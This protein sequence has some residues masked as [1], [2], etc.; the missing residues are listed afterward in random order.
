M[1][2]L[3]GGKYCKD[4]KVFC[5][6]VE[7]E[8]MKLIYN[9]VDSRAFDGQKIRIMP[10][11][12]AG[13]GIV[14]GF[15][16]TIG[17]YV[18]PSHVGVDIGCTISGAFLDNPIPKDK[19]PEFEHKIH[20]AIKFGF[21]I[22]ENVVYDEKEF[23]RFLSKE[24]SK[25]K[26]RC[27]LVSALPDTVTESWISTQLKRLRMDE[28]TFYKSI[29]TVGG[30]N[31]YIELDED[32]SGNQMLTVHCGSRNFG[33]KVCSYW[34]NIAGNQIKNMSKAMKHEIS[35]RAKEI[36]KDDKRKIKE[37]I[38]KLTQEAQ[39]GIINGYLFGE[40]LEGYLCDMVLA[41]AYAKWNH[42]VIHSL[43]YS[44]YS[45]YGCHC[46]D[47]IVTTHN[48][49]DFEDMIIRKG[50]VRSVIGEKLLVPF[51][52]R[53]GVAVCEGLSNP[54]WNCSCSHGAG[55]KMSRNK[56]KSSLDLDTFKHE[57][58][59][60]Y[61]TT[62][63]VDTIDESPMAY[64]DTKTIRDTIDGTTVKVLRMMKPIMNIKATS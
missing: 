15:T 6:D 20:N 5:D 16:S 52:M 64:K 31:H 55:R 58:E 33:V 29:G 47:E 38:N 43:I 63:C 36:C 32:V 44:I 59:G 22:Q 41:Q 14:I 37:T 60:I 7:D 12:H 35:S 46:V 21:D 10:D 8:A 1:T 27:G 42:K 11:V 23:Y 17:K 61:S 2:K 53:D 26:S 40:L 24:F 34:E 50:S 19:I 13:K 57:M 51:N 28:K 30:G 56:A 4:C 45:K 9:I 48:Y 54:D 18:C 3:I 39:K 25:A 62:I 49:I